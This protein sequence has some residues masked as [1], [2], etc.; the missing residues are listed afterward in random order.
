MRTPDCESNAPAGDR[1]VRGPRP[2]LLKLPPRLRARQ[3]P[4]RR[5]SPVEEG[6]P[7]QRRR[8]HPSEGHDHRQPVD[9]LVLP[10]CRM[11]RGFTNPPT[12]SSP[13]YR[14]PE[15]SAPGR[16]F[17]TWDHDQQHGGAIYASGVQAPAATF[18]ER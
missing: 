12:T 9:R 13:D 17:G 11:P 5:P 18:T 14:Q 10:W 6:S 4:R 2:D 8:H 16:D 7:T 1:E 15:T 3:P